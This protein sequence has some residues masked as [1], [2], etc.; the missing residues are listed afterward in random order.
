MA[1]TMTVKKKKRMRRRRG[2]MYGCFCCRVEPTSWAV[3]GGG[4]TLR[5]KLRSPAPTRPVAGKRE[6]NQNETF[7]TTSNP[8]GVLKTLNIRNPKGHYKPLYPF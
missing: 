7:Y 2:K 1:M 5:E 6:A 3:G 8:L 4:R